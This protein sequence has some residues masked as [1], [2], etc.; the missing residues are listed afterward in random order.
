VIAL[1]LAWIIY[2]LAGGNGKSKKYRAMQIVIICITVL[3]SAYSTKITQRYYE[4]YAK[5][6]CGKGMPAIAYIAMALQD[7]VD[8]PGKNNGFHTDVF[9]GNDYNYDMAVS[10]SRQSLQETLKTFR[11]NPGYMFDFFNRK[12][13]A[14]WGNAT[15]GCFW[16]IADRF[17]QPQSDYALDLM[18]GQSKDRMVNIMN[19]C[20]S[21]NY[22]M[23]FAGLV[24]LIYCRFKK[25]IR[26]SL[27]YMIPLITFIGGFLFSLIWE[28]G[29]R[30][31]MAYP[32]L[33]M[34]FAMAQLPKNP[35][36]K[37]K[38]GDIL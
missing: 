25:K 26:I 13:R 7:D 30:Y 16:A 18:Y 21:S 10:L 22:L 31:V 28:A 36:D 4:Y 3:L 34:P 38:I 27:I 20:Q 8:M 17:E 33:L 1:A 32:F 5:N 11:S 24:Y 23:A 12:T 15:G 14:Q 9:M 2:S 35:L 19:I 6:T 37:H 29:P